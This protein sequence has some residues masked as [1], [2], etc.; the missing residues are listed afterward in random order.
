VLRVDCAE[1]V[2]Y[3][4]ELDTHDVV[5]AEGL[6]AETYLDTGNRMAFPNGG[7]ARQLHPDFGPP[8]GSFY[9]V[10]EAL[11]YAP[12]RIVGAEVER[13]R[14]RLEARACMPGGQAAG[15]AA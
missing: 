11:G 4:L 9:L 5:L 14:A 6:A 15:R 12:L 1:M 13:V 10:W 8:P 2:Y 7:G 3:H